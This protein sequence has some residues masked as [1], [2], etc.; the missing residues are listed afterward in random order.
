MSRHHP[1]TAGGYFLRGAIL[2]LLAAGPFLAGAVHEPVFIP[3]LAGCGTRRRRRLVP[4]TTGGAKGR[5]LPPL[6]GRRLIL[7][8]HALV[9]LQ[10]LPLPLPLLRFVQ[11]GLPRHWSHVAARPGRG[12]AANQRQP[13]RHAAR[14]RLR[15]RASRCSSSPSS[16]SWASDPGGGG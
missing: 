1:A 13:A 7:A 6:P 14:P 12:L 2:V 3:L 4:I 16:E 5:R 11:P 10:L 15:R 9:L 8:L